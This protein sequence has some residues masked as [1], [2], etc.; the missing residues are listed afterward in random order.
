[1]AFRGGYI[2]ERNGAGCKH[3]GWAIGASWHDPLHLIL[4]IRVSGIYVYI[5]IHIYTII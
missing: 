1:M 2:G 3:R 4:G 5:Y